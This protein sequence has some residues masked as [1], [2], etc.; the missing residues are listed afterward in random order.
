[1]VCGVNRQKWYEMVYG[2]PEVYG[3]SGNRRECSS[4]RVCFRGDEIAGY[5]KNTFQTKARDEEQTIDK[6]ENKI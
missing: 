2:V 3:A 5:S 4:E 1:M 6:P